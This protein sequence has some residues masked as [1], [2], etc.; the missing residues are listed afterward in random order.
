M[1][2]IQAHINKG[3][4]LFQSLLIRWVCVR[5]EFGTELMGGR[6]GVK[7]YYHSTGTGGDRNKVILE[8]VFSNPKLVS[9]IV[10]GA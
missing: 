6:Y 1:C 8:L 5:P 4:C 2:I 10:E 9:L 7:G 3:F